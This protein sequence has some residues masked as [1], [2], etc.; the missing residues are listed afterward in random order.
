MKAGKKRRVG[1]AKIKQSSG[2]ED[3]LETCEMIKTDVLAD[4]EGALGETGVLIG[5]SLPLP[6]PKGQRV[7]PWA[8]V[9]VTVTMPCANNPKDLKETSDFCQQFAQKRVTEIVKDIISRQK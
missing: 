7:G 9:D 1:S 5:I 2:N 8:K 3:P 6:G 4:Y